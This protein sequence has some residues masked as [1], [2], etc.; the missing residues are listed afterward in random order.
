[1]HPVSFRT[2]VDWTIAEAEEEDRRNREDIPDE[3]EY[4][5]E[6]YHQQDYI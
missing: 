6:H 3:N 2:F 4:D 1:M 5:L